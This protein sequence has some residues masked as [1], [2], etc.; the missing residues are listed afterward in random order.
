MK[1]HNMPFGSLALPTYLWWLYDFKFIYIWNSANTLTMNHL[2][3]HKP[4]SSP[5]PWH[6]GIFPSCNSRSMSCRLLSLLRRGKYILVLTLFRVS[7]SGDSNDSTVLPISE[8]SWLFSMSTHS[9]TALANLSASLKSGNLSVW[10]GNQEN[11]HKLQNLS[12]YMNIYIIYDIRKD[13]GNSWPHYFR[14]TCASGNLEIGVYLALN[15]TSHS[16]F[17]CGSTSGNTV[18]SPGLE[19]AFVL[20]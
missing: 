15:I 18:N 4:L 11:R 14:L 12:S 20:W 7:S 6:L 1:L 17:L 3:H 9:R 16:F 5:A 13:K 19:I 10:P 2:Y 8:P